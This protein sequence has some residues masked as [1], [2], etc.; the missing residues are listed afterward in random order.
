M[1]P[2]IAFYLGATLGFCLGFLMA[3]ILA[4]SDRSEQNQEAI[5]LAQQ[6]AAS[7][8]GFQPVD[9]QPVPEGFTWCPKCQAYFMCTTCPGCAPEIYHEPSQPL[10]H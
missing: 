3:A 9:L 2:Y 10:P 5:K 8:T 4:T 7:C 1:S 6:Q